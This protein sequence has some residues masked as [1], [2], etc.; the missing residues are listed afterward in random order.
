MK[1]IFKLMGIAL[2]ASSMI[3][4]SCNKEEENGGNG[5]GGNNAPTDNYYK[6]TFNGDSWYAAKTIFIDH[7]NEGYVTNYALK[8]AADEAY[9]NDEADELNAPYVYG[10]LESTTGSFTYAQTYD[11]MSYVDGQTVYYEG[12]D[13][14]QP[15]YYG[16]WQTVSSSFVE[17]I[18]AIDLNAHTMSAT[19]SCNVYDFATL[20][21]NNM[22]SY[23]DLY[24]L[25]GELTNYNFTLTAPAE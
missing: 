25:A 9:I 4:V 14:N 16:K 5:N 7:T 19:W 1:N 6:V 18:T 12:D 10:F 11:R 8:N 17:N 21:A 2:L 23:G 22:T 3:L 20:I 24:P 15:G 13:N